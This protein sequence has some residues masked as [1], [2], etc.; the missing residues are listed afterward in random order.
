MAEQADAQDLKSC[1]GDTVPVRFRFRAPQRALTIS[2]SSF[3][4]LFS[5]LAEQK[6]NWEMFL[7]FRQKSTRRIILWDLFLKYVTSSKAS[8]S[9]F[10][11]VDTLS[12]NA[13]V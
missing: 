2:Q 6:Y 5:Q 1:G 8:M 7:N 10:K 12:I 4:M 9:S 3:V 11:S 13:S